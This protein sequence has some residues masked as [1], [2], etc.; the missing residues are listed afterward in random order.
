MVSALIL[1]RE[2]RVMINGIQKDIKDVKTNIGKLFEKVDEANNH[3]SKRLPAWATIAITLLGAL[4]T[5]LIVAA[6]K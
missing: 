3:L 5:G 2:N 4:V 6:V 1:A